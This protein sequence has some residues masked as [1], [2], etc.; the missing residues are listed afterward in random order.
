MRSIDDFRTVLLANKLLEMQHRNAISIN[1]T[2][3]VSQIICLSKKCKIRKVIYFTVYY[4]F[5]TFTVLYQ[6]S[7]HIAFF[8]MLTN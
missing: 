3:V 5:D 1:H 2:F 7:T 8:E 4:E 6:V